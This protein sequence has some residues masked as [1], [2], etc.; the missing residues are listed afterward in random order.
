L[1]VL[2]ISAAALPC[3]P[4]GYGGLEQVVYDLAEE[5]VKTVDVTVACPAES[6]L[7][8][9]VKHLVSN[10]WSRNRDERL[11]Y[12]R[13]A[14]ELDKFDL[15]HDNTHFKFFYYWVKDH[16]EAKYL[17]TLHNPELTIQPELYLN[18]VSPSQANSNYFY[19]K[20]GY[21]TRVVYHGIN[22]SKYKYRKD[23][24]DYYLIMGRPQ[25]IKGSLE[26]VKFCKELNVPCKVIAG[27]LE[28]NPDEYWIKLAQ[29]CKWKSKWEYLG[30]VSHEEKIE[31]LSRAKA[32]IF[33]LNWDIEPFG[34]VIPEALASGT[35]V[36]AYDKGPMREL[37]LPGKTGYL[38]RTPTQFKKAMKRV[39][40]INPLNCY[41]DAL[42]RWDRSI[43]ASNYIQLYNEVLEGAKW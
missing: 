1:N 2:L 3:P 23:K 17:A 15:V 11:A 31:L 27:G 8:P 42:A 41:K 7:P 4:P 33:P 25:P 35:P 10:V 37:I 26:A 21:R 32:Y 30:A 38:P 6:Q 36:I 28:S 5:L 40:H 22:T 16:P 19:N 34:L 39:H 43:M 9:G 29:E 12:V 20:Y 14:G 18:L 13:I 24:E